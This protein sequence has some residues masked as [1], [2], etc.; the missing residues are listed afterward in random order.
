MQEKVIKS[1]SNIESLMLNKL[2]NTSQK[3][4]VLKTSDKEDVLTFLKR[5]SSARKANRSTSKMKN[6]N[7]LRHV[8]SINTDSLAKQN[9]PMQFIDRSSTMD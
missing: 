7:R 9:P 2:Q 8:H 6:N 1:L 5:D 4:N 3:Y